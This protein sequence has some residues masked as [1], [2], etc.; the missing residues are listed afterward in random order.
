MRRGR[1][2]QL[3]AFCTLCR[4][5]GGGDL[6][7]TTYSTPRKSGSAGACRRNAN[8]LRSWM[9]CTSSDMRFLPY[10]CKG[11]GKQGGQTHRAPPDWL[12]GGVPRPDGWPTGGHTQLREANGSN[13]SG[14]IIPFRQRRISAV[15]PFAVA[16][17]SRVGSGTAAPPAAEGLPT[18]GPAP[19]RSPRHAAVAPLSSCSACSQRRAAASSSALRPRWSVRLGSAP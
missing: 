1:G 5:V 2:L 12:V 4:C 3:H 17:A 18:C 15:A 7:E 6:C 14:L 9:Q 10:T 11:A 13:L 19:C 16:C 8:G